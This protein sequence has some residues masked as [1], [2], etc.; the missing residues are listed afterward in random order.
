VTAPARPRP[1]PTGPRPPAPSSSVAGPDS[2]PDSLATD[3]FIRRLADPAAAKRM[4]ASRRDII[5][6][7]KILDEQ[8]EKAE[9]ADAMYDGDVG[10]VYASRQVRR[11][12]ARQ[13]LDETEIEDFNYAAIPVD[14]IA[15]RLQIAAVKVS[16][17]VTDEEA[18]ESDGDDAAGATDPATKKTVK[19]AERAVKALRRANRLDVY[20]KALHKNVSLH[21]DAYLFVWPVTDDSG[22]IVSV[23]MRV[24]SA[25]EVAFIYDE[26]DSLQVAYVIKSWDTPSLIDDETGEGQK[27][28]TRVNLYYPGERAVDEDGE[29]SQGPGRVERWVTQVGASKGKADSWVRVHDPILRG[30]IDADDLEEVAADEFGDPDDPLDKDDIPSPFGLTWFH[31]RNNVPCGVPE[32]IRAYGPQMLINKLVWSYA[33]TVEY[34]GFPQRYVMVDPMQ[35][36][37]LINVSDPD[38]PDD[39]DDDP[40]SG[41]SALSADPS[42]LW[43]LYGK[44]TGQYSAADPDVFMK[45]LDRFIT[46]MSELTGLPR[47]AFTKASADLPSGESVREM[48]GDMIATVIDRQDR[49][50]P[51]WEDAYE[52]ALRMLGITGVAVDVRWVPVTAVND[53]N[54]LNVLKAKAELGVPSEELLNEAGY[55]DEQVSKWLESQE[56]QSLPQ[57]MVILGQLGTA[58]QTL[59]AGVTQGIV[60][61]NQAQALISRFIGLIA[62]GTS[63]SDVTGPDALPAPTFRDPPPTDPAAAA[64]QAAQ[65]DPVKQAQAEHVKAQAEKTKLDTEHARTIGAE[66]AKAGIEATR[67]G[68]ESTKASTAMMKKGD[69]A[70]ATGRR[71]GSAR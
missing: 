60:S 51:D 53:L 45:P 47:Y 64:A 66:A 41:G 30:D 36:D 59:S 61:D 26:E 14:V 23:D 43:R 40:E 10:M 33:G 5:E 6:G 52:L 46:S 55:P 69:P 67:A 12:L 11:L 2:D 16:K 18:E 68:V 15:K 49:Y 35:D 19:K 63:D 42:V 54:G 7:L 1:R 20:E 48:N 22:K 38:H 32:H 17:R 44:S 13:G 3:P 21:G 29:M 62:E 56:T 34:M 31:F 50:D 27:L 8:R 57:R 58:V 28:V 24:N 65:A 25:H 39:E 70:K 9:R 4:Q 71:A 37:P